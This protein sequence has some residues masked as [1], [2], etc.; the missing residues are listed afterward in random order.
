MTTKKITL[1]AKSKTGKKKAQ[2]PI[3]LLATDA[4]ISIVTLD[5]NGQPMSPPTTADKVTTD[6]VV[7]NTALLNVAAGADSQ[8]Y[9]FTIP[10]NATGTVNLT[11][12]ETFVD[13]SVGPF[14]D[15]VPL[16]LPTPP[17]PVATTIQVVIS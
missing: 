1:T 12:T 3:Q 14:E 8:H 7:D 6:V 4:N 17:A 11:V 15:V 5:Q 2:P 9:T 10:A 16:I 13:G